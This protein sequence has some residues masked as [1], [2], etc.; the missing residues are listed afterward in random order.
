MFMIFSIPKPPVP[1]PYHHLAFSLS[2]MPTLK[3]SCYFRCHRLSEAVNVGEGWGG[4]G[5]IWEALG[6]GFSHARAWRDF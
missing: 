1:S 6:E 3:W 4:M 5:Y 2:V